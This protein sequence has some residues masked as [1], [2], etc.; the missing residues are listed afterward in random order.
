M[1]YIRAI[2][3]KDLG[4]HAI[5]SRLVHYNRYPVVDDAKKQHKDASACLCDK[6]L[7]LLMELQCWFS[8]QEHLTKAVLKLGKYDLDAL[9]VLHELGNLLVSAEQIGNVLS[10]QTA[11][12]ILNF[13]PIRLVQILTILARQ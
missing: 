9:F 4:G 11:R 2:K 7:N 13:F 8:I 1:L 12:V 6:S 5:N 10:L 3:Y